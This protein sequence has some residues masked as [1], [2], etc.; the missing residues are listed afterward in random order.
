[1]CCKWWFEHWG[2]WSVI[3]EREINQIKKRQVMLY[4][5]ESLSGGGGEEGGGC[6]RKE[7]EE[8]DRRECI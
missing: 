3:I 8:Q 7:L 6:S 2:L 5:S 4:S 1:M